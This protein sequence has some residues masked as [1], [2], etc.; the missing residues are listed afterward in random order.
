M[1]AIDVKPAM[2]D[3]T[4]EAYNRIR[5][6][7][8]SNCAVPG[9]FLNI[10]T[11]AERLRVSATPV[12][13]ALI[14]LS[15]EEV[16][17]F[18]KGR[19]YYIKALDPDDLTADYELATILLKSSIESR[20][21]THHEPQQHTLKEIWQGGAVRDQPHAATI[22]NRVETIYEKIAW[23][24]GNPRLVASIAC[25]CARTG[26]IRQFGLLSAP[27]INDALWSLNGLEEAISSGNRVL[28]SRIL[29]RHTRL[30]CEAVPELVREFNLRAQTNRSPLE[31][32]L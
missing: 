21:R 25:F 12:R 23:T 8:N 29:I 13:E 5:A 3:K 28:A 2:Q 10:R 4:R 6:V 1:Q 22:A 27:R 9:A 26:H 20:N 19:G 30:I 32:L 14:R 15:H 31:D 16:I 17:G 11:V 18:I 7:L 24:S